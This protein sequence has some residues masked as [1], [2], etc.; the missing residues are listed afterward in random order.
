MIISTPESSDIDLIPS[1]LCKLSNL[2]H[3]LDPSSSYNPELNHERCHYLKDPDRYSIFFGLREV[4]DSIWGL[5]EMID[6]KGMFILEDKPVQIPDKEVYVVY[7][8]PVMVSEPQAIEEELDNI[9]F[10]KGKSYGIWVAIH[11]K[12][13]DRHVFNLLL[14]CLKYKLLSHESIPSFVNGFQYIGDNGF[15]FLCQNCVQFLFNCL[16]EREVV[17]AILIQTLYEKYHGRMPR[18]KMFRNVDQELV[19]DMIQESFMKVVK[20]TPK[21]EI[22]EIPRFLYTVA[23]RTIKDHWRKVYRDRKK[24]E[25]YFQFKSLNLNENEDVE[26]NEKKI[27]NSAL[28]KLKPREQEIIDLIYKKGLSTKKT[29]ETLSCPAGTVKSRLHRIRKKLM[30]DGDLKIFIR[31]N[32]A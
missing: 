24:M 8:L 17:S 6:E 20:T 9:T 15:K 11:I 27:V 1:T 5:V 10:S 18:W 30:K 13:D 28:L 2:Y 21:S 29:A 22:K 19:K 3:Y 31:D 4:N 32:L 25:R 16:I 12:Y 7:Q 26:N 23:N 14:Q